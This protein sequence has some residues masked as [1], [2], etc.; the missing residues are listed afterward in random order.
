MIY[1]IEYS[2][3]AKNRDLNQTYENIERMEMNK[4]EL[5]DELAAMK[6]TLNEKD[7]EIRKYLIKRRKKKTIH[8]LL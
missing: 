5:M 7:D 2:L 8:I 4:Q 6:K 1:F 3:A